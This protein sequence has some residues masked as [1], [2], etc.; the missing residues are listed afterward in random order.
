M[1]KII[2]NG[3]EF[4]GT[5][6]S[7]NNINYDNSVS[8]LEARTAQ[9][10]IDTLSDSLTASDNLK[11]QFAT[12]GEGNY[13]YLKGDDTFVPFKGSLELISTKQDVKTH[14]T[15]AVLTAT[16]SYTH[17]CVK[18]GSAIVILHGSN[19]SGNYG[20]I[21]ESVKLNDVEQN[22]SLQIKGITAD[23][24]DIFLLDCK[25]GDVIDLSITT[26]RQNSAYMYATYALYA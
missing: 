3:I 15:G 7:A 6:D 11:F 8:G 1:G 9:E 10:A 21:T 24:A 2:R 14:P 5:S 19:E 13:G 23:F 25:A 20:S 17:T 4:S 26:S 12:D 18:S 22:K 16:V